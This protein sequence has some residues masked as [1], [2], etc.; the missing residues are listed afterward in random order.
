M[1]AKTL[2]CI[3]L[4]ATLLSTCGAPFMLDRTPET[5]PRPSPVSTSL[6]L[7]S[8]GASV[9]PPEPG[10]YTYSS[11]IKG[12]AGETRLDHLDEYRPAVE[13][14]A[15]IFQQKVWHLQD[16]GSR[17]YFV[18]T[19]WRPEAT[20]SA[21]QF[22]ISTGM[23]YYGPPVTELRFPLKVG[24]TWS[25][26]SFCVNDSPPRR[27]VSGRSKVVRTQNQAIGGQ[28][29]HTFVIDFS[30]KFVGDN[31]GTYTNKGTLWYSP[32]YRITVKQSFKFNYANQRTQGEYNAEL[33]NLTPAE[34][35][36]TFGRNL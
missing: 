8:Q 34:L 11:V 10:V 6:P 25:F 19:L 12:P 14:A 28:T 9:R 23:C 21:A 7:P 31:S 35:S 24:D 36:P 32:D 1:N 29:V 18:D 17:P 3:V 20:Y 22:F 16:I 2:C 5:S 30:A 4:S 15:G 33:K 27:E 26:R 13:I